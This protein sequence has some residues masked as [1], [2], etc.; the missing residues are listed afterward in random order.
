MIQS[1][2]CNKNRHLLAKLLFRVTPVYKYYK[3]Y[4]KTQWLSRE[5]IEALQF[6]RAKETLELAY[7]FHVFYKKKFKQAGVHPTH[8]KQLSDLSNF[9]PVDR[10]ELQN[11]LLN[12]EFNLQFV[13][14][15]IKQRAT[16]GSTGNPFIFPINQSAFNV[17]VGCLF[18]TIVW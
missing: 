6:N 15:P 14:E 17:R 10:K 13:N 1:K 16:T 9:P 7:K 12:D 8:F 5:A 3:Y 2:A 11:A 4:K 18:R